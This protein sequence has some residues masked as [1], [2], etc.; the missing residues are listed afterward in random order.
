MPKGGPSKTMLRAELYLCSK[1]PDERQ[2]NIHA[3]RADNYAK[4]LFGSSAGY[5]SVVAEIEEMRKGNR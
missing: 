1:A 3:Q 2:F 4:A 5:R